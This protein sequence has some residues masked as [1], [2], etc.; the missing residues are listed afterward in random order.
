MPVNKLYLDLLAADANPIGSLEK[1]VIEFLEADGSTESLDSAAF[2]QVNGSKIKADYLLGNRG[3]VAELKT[4]NASPKD[5]TERRLKERFSQ[6]DAPI[7]FGSVGVS[8]VI[9]DLPDRDAISKMMIDMAGRAVRRHLQ[10]AN[11]Q[12]E[13]I[14]SRLGL[15]D[16]GGVLILMNEAETMIDAAAIGYTLKTAF[17][18]VEGGYPHVTNVWAIIE[19]HRIEMPGGRRGFPHLHVF[20]LVERE[21][22]L[23]YIG[24]MLAAWGRFSGSRM[25]RIEHHGDWKVMRPI[26]DG[27]PPI[28]Q[29]FG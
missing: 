12:I 16:S 22:E 23:E 24:R 10:K 15:P 2:D 4:L 5:R 27:E 25:E 17:E 1:R 3:L 20:K 7:V 14:K 9:A 29:P 26:Y 11:D 13:A 19:S 18:T 21:A 28:L 8:R 6:P